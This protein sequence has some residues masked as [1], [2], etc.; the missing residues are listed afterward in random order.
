MTH[1]G[2]ESAFGLLVVAALMLAFFYALNKYKTRFLER[3]N[4]DLTM[5]SQ[6][7]VGY[8]Q[9]LMLIKA[10]NKTILLAVSHDNTT[11][12]EAWDD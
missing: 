11:V 7:T 4:Q 9:R 12:V 1:V 2:L 8:R 6:I 3:G 5:T 10:R